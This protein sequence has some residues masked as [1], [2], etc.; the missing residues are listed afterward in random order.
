MQQPSG[1]VA[2]DDSPKHAV[3][4]DGGDIEDLRYSIGGGKT[5]W[6]PSAKS[7]ALQYLLD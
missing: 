3:D 2:I 1:A 7:E 5:G 6:L 4:M